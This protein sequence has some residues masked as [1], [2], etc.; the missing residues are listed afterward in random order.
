MGEYVFSIGTSY[1]EK[2]YFGLNNRVTLV[3]TTMKTLF[4]QALIF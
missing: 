1:E 4:T 3:S 2:I